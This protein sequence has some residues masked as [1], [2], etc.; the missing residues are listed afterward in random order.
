M[1]LKLCPPHLY[2]RFRCEDYL[3]DT[4]VRIT[5]V[6]IEDECVDCEAFGNGNLPSF[7][8]PD[9]IMERWRS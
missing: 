3:Y 7:A 6:M 9:R 5:H 8:D 4:D 1:M 2:L